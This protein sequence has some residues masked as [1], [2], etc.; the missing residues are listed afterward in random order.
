MNVRDVSGCQ[1][2]RDRSACD[3]SA[4]AWIL[5]V[6][7][8]REIPTAC[9]QAPFCGLS[10]AVSFHMGAVET[11]LLREAA[12]TR[13]SR[14]A[15]LEVVKGECTVSELAADLVC[16]RRRSISGRRRRW[17][18][19]GYLRARQ[20]EA[21]RGRRGDHPVAACRDREL[22]VANDPPQGLRGPPGATVL[23]PKSRK[24]KPWTGG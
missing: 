10:R 16:I 2:K 5:L 18:C 19:C 17:R 14:R 6:A 7:P 4:S 8:P 20:P 13:V 3:A 23:A 24:L 21:F 9:G 1:G 12:M 15:A 11:E 22:A